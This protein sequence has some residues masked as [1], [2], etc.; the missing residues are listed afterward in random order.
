MNAFESVELHFLRP[1]TK[2]TREFCV[3][4]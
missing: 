2:N 1:V 4:I 3:G